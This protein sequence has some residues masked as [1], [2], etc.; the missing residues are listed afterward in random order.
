M[1]QLDLCEHLIFLL[2]KNVVCLIVTCPI[3]WNMIAAFVTLSMSH[4]SFMMWMQTH[5][6]LLFN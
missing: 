4:M 3:S 1:S 5:L 2:K 6:T